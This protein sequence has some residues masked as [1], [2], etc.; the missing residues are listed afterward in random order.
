MKLYY[1]INNVFMPTNITCI[2][3]PMDQGVSL[4]FKS[5]YLI[6]I[7]QMDLAAINS[8]SSDRCEKKVKVVTPSC[9]TLRPH[10]L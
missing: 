1:E 8:D 9:L 7:F 10:G 3:Q 2:L 4:T 6:N 5:Y